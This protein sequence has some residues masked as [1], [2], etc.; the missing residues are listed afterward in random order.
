MGDL[1]FIDVFLLRRILSK[2]KTIF[3]RFSST[4]NPRNVYEIKK[5]Y[6]NMA[7]PLY[8]VAEISY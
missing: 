4:L 3:Q 2:Y 6:P 8:I 1:L 7:D 5:H